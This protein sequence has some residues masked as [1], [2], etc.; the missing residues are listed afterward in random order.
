MLLTLMPTATY[1]H[2]MKRSCGRC[3]KRKDNGIA[4]CRPCRAVV[5]AK[6]LR[7]HPGYMAAAQARWLRKNRKKAAGACRKW[8]QKNHK[9][10]ALLAKRWRDKNPDDCKKSLLRYRASH[11]EVVRALSRKRKMRIRGARGSHTEQEWQI[12]L[13][14]YDNLCRY[15]RVRLTKHNRSR[16]HRIPIARGGTDGIKNIVPACRSC[17]SRKHLS[18]EKEYVKR[19]LSLVERWSG[20]GATVVSRL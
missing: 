20:C 4:Y 15:C 13:A 7:K 16:D 10:T 12:L 1:P 17:N 9:R 11:P 18:T 8:Q 19:L 6:W 3:G 2:P 14:V 5:A